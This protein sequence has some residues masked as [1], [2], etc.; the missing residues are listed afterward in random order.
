MSPLQLNYY[1]SLPFYPHEISIDTITMAFNYYPLCNSTTL[2]VNYNINLAYNLLL[3]IAIY[4][5]KIQLKLL[6]WYWT[7]TDHGNSTHINHIT[8]VF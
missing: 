7:I 2:T 4:H 8:I 6:L 1:S 5:M 3:I